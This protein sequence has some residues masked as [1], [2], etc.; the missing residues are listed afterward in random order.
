MDLYSRSAAVALLSTALTERSHYVLTA[1]PGAA[2]LVA[3]RLTRLAWTAYLDQG[4]EEIAAVTQ[5]GAVV[6]AELLTE[7]ATV[8]LVPIRPGV[9]E[10]LSAALGV[11]VSPD[12]DILAIATPDGRAAWPRL[13]VDAIDRVDPVAAAQIR[14]AAV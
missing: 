14:A 1:P 7:V 8:I 5:V 9:A 6:A 10:Y 2:A 3:P 4:T 12:R 11:A 13:L